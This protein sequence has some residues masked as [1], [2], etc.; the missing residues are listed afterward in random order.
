MQYTGDAARVRGNTSGATPR[1]HLGLAAGPRERRA[2]MEHSVAGKRDDVSPYLGR[3][4]GARDGSDR[5]RDPAILVSVGTANRWEESSTDARQKYLAA[6]QNLWAA[7][8][9][10]DAETS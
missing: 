8:W 3:T 6:L 5:A 2:Y 7:Y 10:P 1:R 9:V 4:V